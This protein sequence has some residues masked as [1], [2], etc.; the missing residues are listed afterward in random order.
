MSKRHRDKLAK[1]K[2]EF[3]IN[4]KEYEDSLKEVCNDIIKGSSSADNE[5]TVVSI[6]ELELFSFIKETLQLKYYPE[7]EK[8]ISTERHVSKGR[9]D[10]K[11][12]ALIIEFKQPSSFDSLKKKQKATSQLTD[13]LNGL[14]SSHKADY[15]GVV[16]DGSECQNLVMEDGEISYGAYDKLNSKHL[17]LIIRN[18]VLLDKVALTPVNLVKDFCEPAGESLS[19]RLT[20]KLYETLKS[21]STGKSK[22]LFME[23][24]E[25]FRLAHDDKSKQKAIQER[26]E[27]LEKVV[28]SKLNVQDDEYLALYALQTTYAIIVKIIAYKVTSK[29]RFNK[30]LIDFNSL[31]SADSES[32]RIQLSE[33]E[34]GA[35]FR[36]LGIG[37]LLEG[38]FFSWYCSD[39]QWNTDISKLVKEIFS[40]LT[41]YEDK[42]I[43]EQGD[44]ATDLFKDLFL[45]II[46]SKVRHSLGE[47]YTP[48]W[49]ADNLVT[50]AI[51]LANIKSWKGIDPC[52]GSGTFVTVMIRKVL[53]ETLGQPNEERLRTVLERVKGIDLNPLAVLTARINYFINISPLIGESQEFEIPIYLGDASYVPERTTVDKIKCLKYSI[54]TI[55]GEIEIVLPASVVDNPDLFS[56]T[57]TSIEEDIKNLDEE[58]IIAKLLELIPAK[59]RSSLIID[60]VKSLANKFIELEQ[61]EWNGIWARII[62]NFL[63]TA[64]LGKFDLI[65]GNPPWIDWKNLPA[66]YRERVKGLC[67]GRNLFSGDGITGGINLNVCAL[68]SNVSAQNWLSKKGVLA[69]L[70]PQSLIFQQ[71]Y[72]GF[73][74][75]RLDKGNLYLQRISDWTKSGHPFKPVQQ[76]FLSYFFSSNK[77]DYDNGIDSKHYKK[78]NRQNLDKYIHCAEF[79]QVAHLFDV[80][81]K[82]IGHAGSTNSI[83]SY[84][85]NLEE[86][87]KYKKVSGESTYK[88]REG[89]EFYPQELFLLEIDNSIKKAPKGKVFVKNFQNSKSKYKIPQQTTLLETK[90]LHPLVKG[91]DITRFHLK[92]SKYLVP[93]PYDDKNTR[94]PIEI[95]RLT[96][97]SPLLA[98]YF[99]KF[100]KTIESQTDYNAKI[101]GA[102]H[103]SE[104]YALARVGAYSFAEHYVAFRDNTK[105]V[106]CVVSKQTTPW[107]EEKRAQFQNHAVS[108]CQDNKGRFITLEEAHFICAVLN[109]PITEKYV[110]N[111]SDSRTFKIRPQ[112]NIPEYDSGNSIHKE[113]SELSIQAHKVYDNEEEINK[114]DRKLDLLV[115]KL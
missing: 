94:S 76:K 8:S 4:S 35:I 32:L 14:Y 45:R 78:N 61:N 54:K 80:E 20:I 91:V 89:V 25:L 13:Y 27:S 55:K 49:L 12:G 71:T 19:E 84:A 82:I 73:R 64:N 69:F 96:K 43:F 34:E 77:V 39:E 57:M 40:L 88:G 59:E 56:S 18:I 47:F 97:E 22:M 92:E 67:V 114:I 98:K 75:F 36:N 41:P 81:N 33:L 3:I 110:I 37:N 28:G 111:S 108:I 29:M 74:E 50:E 102:K 63:T 101:I 79:S 115:V 53:K 112:V 113:L 15:L 70:M 48:P 23:W 90:F 99:N 103:N 10:S 11:I 109:A 52:S 44:K 1:K 62:T 24:K 86:L 7:K 85:E 104:F 72:E 60:H 9:I 93:F 46:P 31:S 26:R 83:F 21:N 66:G 16:T 58:S 65:V 87:K 100:K 38:D 42:A 95:K 30:S 106:S 6:F 2:I 68:V 5:A 17:D 107:G 51:A 105:W